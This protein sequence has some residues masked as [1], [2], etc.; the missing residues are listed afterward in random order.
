MLLITVPT[1]LGF[2]TGSPSGGVAISVSILGGI[3]TFSPKTAALIYMGAYL[4]YVIAPTYLCLTF[5]A[6]YF[7]SPLD[8]VYKHHILATFRFHVKA[9]VFSSSVNRSQNT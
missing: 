4:G 3:L 6:G 9:F 8:K 5:T 2:L 7:K 1:F